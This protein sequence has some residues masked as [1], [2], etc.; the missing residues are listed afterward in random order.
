ME[1]HEALPSTASSTATAVALTT[2]TAVIDTEKA[3]TKD[4]INASAAESFNVDD[5]TATS[6]HDQDQRA[7]IQNRWW[8]IG[9]KSTTQDA[10]SQDEGGKKENE[11]SE[12]SAPFSN[13]LRVFKYSNRMDRWLLALT[14][15]AA[16]ATGAVSIPANLHHRSFRG[17]HHL[18]ICNRRCP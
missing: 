18:L 13:Y 3:T 14:T 8:Q 17:M 12:P 15:I 9:K 11:S 5:S 4:T 2:T 16:M 1:Q 7:N 6:A 10:K